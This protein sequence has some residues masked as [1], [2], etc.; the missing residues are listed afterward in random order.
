MLNKN[1][2]IPQIFVLLL[3]CAVSFTASGADII[4]RTDRP[5][6]A[7]NESFTLSYDVIGKLPGQPDFS[8]LQQHFDIVNTTE[9]SSLNIVNGQSTRKHTWTLTLFAKRSGTLTIPAI[10]FGQQSSPEIQIEVGQTPG[11][12]NAATGNQ[13]VFL[14]VTAEPKNPYVQQQVVY[15]LRLY[16]AVNL[17]NATLSNPE[18]SGNDAVFKPFGEDRS[19]DTVLNGR[20]YRVFER[21]FVLFPQ[22][23]GILTIQ[24]VVLDAR[25][26]GSSRGFFDPFG[27]SGQRIRLLSDAVTLNVRSPAAAFTGNTWLPAAELQLAERWSADPPEFTVGE[28]ITRTI[29]ISALGLTAA[30]LPELTLQHPAAFKAYPDKATLNDTEQSGFVLGRRAEK[31]ALIPMQ[32]GA[33]ILAAIEIPWWSSKD[34]QLKIA[35]LPA[36]TVQ[37]MAGQTGAETPSMV[38]SPPP[39]STTA[40]QPVSTVVPEPTTNKYAWLSALLGFA[41]MITAVAWWWQS[42]TQHKTIQDNKKPASETSAKVYLKA[43]QRACKTDNAREAK[44]ALLDWANAKWPHFPTQNLNALANKAAPDLAAEILELNRHLYRDSN[45]NWNGAALWQALQNHPI[46]DATPD[47]THSESLLPLHKIHG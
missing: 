3:L 37:V 5:N 33:Y 16:R 46:Q 10:R 36:R 17:N 43:L 9:S 44:N 11:S 22:S 45:N 42:R 25:L 12:T 38:V 32:A 15:T 6:V 27:S 2:S 26:A 24:P 1:S 40:E 31:T 4:T 29:T 47:K 35:R 19:F 23:P 39:L 28:P 34:N 7:L 8:P 41:W 30:Q 20:R 21:Q 18:F 14:Q 13:D